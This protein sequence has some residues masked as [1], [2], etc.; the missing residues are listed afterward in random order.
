MYYSD[1]HIHSNFSPDVHPSRR[2]SVDDICSTAYEIGLSHVAVTDHYEPMLYHNENGIQFPFEALVR[3]TALAKEKW[4]GR[5]SVALGIE[6]GQPHLEP[7]QTQQVLS[8]YPFDIV[9][10]S[11]HAHPTHGE[12]IKLN[13]AAMTD[14][15]RSALLD[16]YLEHYEI[17]ARTSPIDVIT[18][19]TYPLRYLLQQGIPFDMRCW[20]ERM[21]AIFRTII[22]RGIGLEFNAAPRRVPNVGIP[23]HTVE[24]L[25]RWYHDEGGRIVTFASDAHRPE[26]I[27]AYCQSSMHILRE[28]GFRY[29]AVFENRKP[30]F[31]SI[32]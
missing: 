24:T 20:E 23:D 28:I 1:S 7:E 26:D 22:A 13:Y 21:R 16:A 17:M 10:G 11:L 5:V 25:M 18:H 14:D 8:A 15:E 19:P 30:V 32:S 31:H 27:G 6:Y 12:Y 2:A 29:I 9:L 3:D 4:R